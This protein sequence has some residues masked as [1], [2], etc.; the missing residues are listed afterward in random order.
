M[1][2]RSDLVGVVSLIGLLA[3]AGA[4]CERA[5]S[6]SSNAGSASKGS[7]VAT[8]PAVP[9]ASVPAQERVAVVNAVP[10]TVTDVELAVEDLKRLVQAYQQTWKPL[11]TEN[12]PDALDLGDVASNLIDAELKAQDVKARGLDRKTEFRRR[13]AFLERSFSAQEWDRWQRDRSTP[14]EEQI[15]QFYEQNKT[16]FTDPERIHARQIVANTLA[17]AE[18]VRA[19]AVQGTTFASLAKE[20]SVGAGKDNGGDIGWHL[21]AVDRERLTMLGG[22][23]PSESI[24]F[25]QLEPVA[26]ALE[27]GQISQPVK[28]PEEKFY[29]VTVEERKPSRQQ[30]EVEVH[31][32]IKGLL[33]LQN[34]QKAFQELRKPDKAKIE[35]FAERLKDVK[36]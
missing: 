24:F 17:D 8:S 10:I 21:R 22:Q 29:L 26:F 32:A 6:S 12:V 30:T 25:P 36:Q 23:A 14:T 20:H 33:T 9:E 18:A 3:L 15:H 1:R 35:I 11:P 28:G 19:Q 27:V 5:N 7:T 13:L 2:T 16:G 34:M 4:G 31:D